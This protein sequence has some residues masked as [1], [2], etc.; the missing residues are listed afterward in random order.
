MEE[1]GLHFTKQITL[2]VAAA[3][4]LI[5]AGYD[6]RIV[7]FW[8]GWWTS[9]N[10]DKYALQFMVKD[11]G[12]PLDPGLALASGTNSAFRAV[13]IPKLADIYQ[14]NH[15]RGGSPWVLEPAVLKAECGIDLSI[16]AYGGRNTVDYVSDQ[17]RKIDEANHAF[18]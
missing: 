4:R 5:A 13:V 2:A 3:D 10:H 9:E 16:A 1:T 6:I 11:F 12:A 14:F 17:L 7:G 18:C 15:M 8:S